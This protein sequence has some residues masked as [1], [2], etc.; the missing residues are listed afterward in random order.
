MNNIIAANRPGGSK[1]DPAGSRAEQ[2]ENMLRLITDY[3]KFVLTE[4]VHTVEIFE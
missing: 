2:T 3:N 1:A 4:G